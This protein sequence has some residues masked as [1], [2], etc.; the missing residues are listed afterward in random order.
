M[1]QKIEETQY[2]VTEENIDKVKEEMSGCDQTKEL[3]PGCITWGI[4]YQPG[5]QR[6]QMT[7]W[8]NDRGAVTWGADSAWGEW[9]DDVLILDDGESKVDEDGNEEEASQ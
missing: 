9:W 4:I 3:V 8:P 5:S 2:I 7:R 1:N 6:G